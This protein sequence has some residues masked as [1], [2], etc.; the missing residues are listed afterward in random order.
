MNAVQWIN[1]KYH[2]TAVSVPGFKAGDTLNVHVKIKEGEKERVQVFT[3]VVIRIHRN[4]AGSSF[5]IRK[6]SY[7]VGV[8]RIFPYNSPNIEKIEVLS[9]GRV[10]R[11]KLYYLRNLSGKKARITSLGEG[12]A[13]LIKQGS[14]MAEIVPELTP[15]AAAEEAASLE[16]AAKPTGGT[17]EL[18]KP[19]VSLETVAEPR[20]AETKKSEKLDAQASK[21]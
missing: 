1:E 8:E 17:A 2:A 5:T 13:L 16:A 4:A 14:E 12:A 18:A 7:G 21:K 6:V 10:R 11:A 15:Q 9:V 3:G 19:A 20:A